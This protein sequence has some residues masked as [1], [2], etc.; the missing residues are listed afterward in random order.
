MNF[1]TV[2]TPTYN[3][4][5]TLK[6]LFDSLCKQTDKRFE[7]IV[8]DD[9]STDSTPA[10][11]A[12]L[13]E[14]APFA[15]TIINK[16]NGGK[17]AAINDG[18]AV[19]KGEF[20]FMIDSDDY[21]A[22]KTVEKLFSWCAEI[23]NDKSFV[24]VGAAKA[25]PDGKYL[26]GVPPK[27]NEK[28]FVDATNLERKLYDLDVDMCEAYKTDIFKKFPFVTWQGENF[29]PEQIVLNEMALCG[30]KLR[31]HK[32]IVYY[33]D[34]LED[35]LTRGSNRLIKR[36]PMGYAM[37]YDHMLKY[38]YPLKKRLRVACNMTALAAYG[39]HPFYFFKC[40]SKLLGLL[41]FIPGLCL[42]VRRRRQ[43]GDVDD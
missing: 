7:W 30:Y 21:V 19:A 14:C 20:F 32:D 39:K 43:F 41:T 22:P 2:F 36:N 8:V 15:M 1:L 31:W 11:L 38:G 25:Y 40:N 5:H 27:V 9:G 6:R 4:A 26:K 29:V 18:L 23:E 10:L 37:M 24:G 3:R 42:S 35:G 13:K 17:P 16:K 34:Y 28:G 33:C 12:E